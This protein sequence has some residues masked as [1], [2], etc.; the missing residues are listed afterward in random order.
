MSD[1]ERLIASI[2]KFLSIVDEMYSRPSTMKWEAVVKQTK[3]YTQ[4]RKELKLL[5][6]EVITNDTK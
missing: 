4:C 2:N 1:L 6:K 3:K 5:I